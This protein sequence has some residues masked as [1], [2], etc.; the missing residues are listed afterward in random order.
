[1]VDI[2]TEKQRAQKKFENVVDS[3][4]H[5]YDIKFILLKNI[6]S[7]KCIHHARTLGMYQWLV[8]LY[9]TLPYCTR[10]PEKN[11][12]R[13]SKP[14]LPVKI[15]ITLCITGKRN[16]VLELCLGGL[17]AGTVAA[18]QNLSRAGLARYNPF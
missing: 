15:F 10:L 12:A 18:I 8:Y 1:M 3:H 14:V 11:R 5:L 13:I 7:Q 4:P 17:L 16:G 6:A 2:M 9:V